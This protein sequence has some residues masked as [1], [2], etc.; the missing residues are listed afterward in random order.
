MFERFDK[1]EGRFVSDVHGVLV[2]KSAAEGGWTTIWE[3]PNSASHG[4]MQ[5]HLALQV[6]GDVVCSGECTYD[7]KMLRGRFSN[8]PRDWTISID[9]DEFHRMPAHPVYGAFELSVWPDGRLVGRIGYA[10]PETTPPQRKVWIVGG[11]DLHW[12]HVVWRP[13]AS[14]PPSDAVG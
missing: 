6:I 13:V 5:R 4:L 10:R 3:A 9:I 1:L 12:T 14:L 11:E 2:L 8:V 7:G